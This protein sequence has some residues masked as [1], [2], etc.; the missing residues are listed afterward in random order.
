MRLTF[1]SLAILGMLALSGCT[2]ELPPEQA[3]DLL[4]RV[5]T[6]RR[7]LTLT[8]RLSTS[9]QMQG[10]QLRADAEMQRAPGIIHLTYTSGRFAGWK[11][12]EQDGL[13]WRISPE[14]K[15]EASPISPETGL[16]LPAHPGLSIRDGGLIRRAGRI[17]RRYIVHP[18]GENTDARLV[19]AVDSKT[20][21][22]LS[23]QRYGHGGTLVS[24]TIYREVTYGTP[25]PPRIE[26]PAQA[27]AWQ[28]RRQGSPAKMMTEQELEKAVG[29]K[30]LKPQYVP[31][32]F[33]LRGYFLR[34]TRRMTLGE[35]RY[36]DGLRTLVVS[37]G[38]A[39][40]RPQGAAAEPRGRGPGEG[41][42]RPG[43][44]QQTKQPAGAK[45]QQD[46]P[47]QSEGGPW[48]RRGGWWQRFRQ[49]RASQGTGPGG[50]RVL[51]DRRGDR[52][53][54]A[55][56]DL[57]PEE[58]RKTIDSVPQLETGRAGTKF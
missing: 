1:L 57:P 8:G 48:D 13:V 37:Q 26:P 15:P 58:L 30:L 14:G 56:G 45:A 20:G 5:H 10:R 39:P 43:E 18:P 55:S 42:G 12:I 46:G 51:R 36:S 6:A 28:Q 49:E 25:P 35:I 19:I 34:E 22:P 52:V 29:W 41:S 47:R 17:A 53:I 2:R 21:Y 7:T 9:I 32:G 44:R 54:I 3:R 27:A 4:Q 16:G 33:Q 24:A 38:K 40:E 11:L 31:D 23:I 50:R